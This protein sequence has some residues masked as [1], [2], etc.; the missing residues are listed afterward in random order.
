MDFT[1]IISAFRDEWNTVIQAPFS[2]FLIAVIAFTAAYLASRWRYS[3]VVEQ[4]RE[5]MNTLQ[6]RLLQKTEQAEN[7]KD[8]ALKFDEKLSEV[9]SSDIPELCART[10]A[11]VSRLRDFIHR[12]KVQNDR[13]MRPG[14]LATE[15]S[16]WGKSVD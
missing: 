14:T 16:D 1:R 13:E 4:V 11:F 12:R 5:Q 2:F 10:L 7:Y 3:G 15:Q 8:R 9:V 6:Q